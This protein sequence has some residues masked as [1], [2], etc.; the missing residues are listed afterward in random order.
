[1]PPP[2]KVLYIAGAGRTGSTLIEKLLGQLDGVFAGGELTFLWGYAVRGRCS[3][4]RGLVACPVWTAIF[5]EAF[6]GFAGI[7]ADEMVRLRARSDSRSLPLLASRFAQRRLGPYPERV[8]RL[9]AAIGA[10]TGARVIVDSSKEPHYAWIL[11]SRRALDVRVLHLVRDPRAVAHSWAKRKEQAG[12][13][14]TWMEQRSAAVS[15]AYYAVSN[16]AAEALFAR[17]RDRYLRV[18]YE[19]AIADPIALGDDLSAL[20][21]EPMDLRAVLPDGHRG[22]VRETH[23]AWGNP[24]RFETGPVTLRLDAAW[25]DAPPTRERRI[26]EA[27]NGPL[28]RHYGYT[29]VRHRRASELP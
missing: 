6:G 10:T 9:Y 12:I 29:G 27:L 18:R 15:S 3:C 22:V 17:D 19:D 7:D 28:L 1:M 11:R 4:G 25:R 23:S 13:P 26:V 14:G 8:E 2:V 24:N 20:M 5:D 16:V 21:G